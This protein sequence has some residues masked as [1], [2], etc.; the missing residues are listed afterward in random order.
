MSRAFCI[1]GIAF[2]FIALVLNFLTSISL[3]YLTALDIARSSFNEG[4]QVQGT[5][6]CSIFGMPNIACRAD[7]R[8]DEHGDRTCA[9]AH[10]S[11]S[12]FLQN[13]DRTET[14]DIGASWTRGLAIHPVATGVTFIAF[15]LS[16]STHITVTLFSS[17]I[18]FLAAALTLIAFAVDIALF[19]YLKHQL[20][21]LNNVNAHTRPGPGFWLTLVAFVMLLLAG[22]TVCFGRRKQRM[23][24]AASYPSYP[25]KDTKTG[26]G[27]LS[28]FRRNRA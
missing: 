13:S 14:V 3:P 22:C 1:P 18:S 27:F 23:A 2:L 20:K 19:A 4:V 16:F 7:C 26:G 10:S 21:K 28:R 5:T 25:M 11:Y 6:K 9:S 24:G 8:Y 15:A 12:V 17:L